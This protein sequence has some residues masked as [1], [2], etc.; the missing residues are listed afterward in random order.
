MESITTIE[1]ESNLIRGLSVTLPKAIQSRDIQIPTRKK[2][3][4]NR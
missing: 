3:E 1:I 2:L 4:Q